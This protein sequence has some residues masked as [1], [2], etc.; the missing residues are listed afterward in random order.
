MSGLTQHERG[1]VESCLGHRY[2][3]LSTQEGLLLE[4]RLGEARQSSASLPL[5]MKRAWRRTGLF[6]GCAARATPATVRQAAAIAA[7]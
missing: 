7:V 2:H 6:T 5:N 1:E 4:P 3:R